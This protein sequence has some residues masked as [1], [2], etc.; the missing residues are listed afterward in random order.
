MNWIAQNSDVVVSVAGAI[1][2]SAAY[3]IGYLI[4]KE[5][6]MDKGFMAGKDLTTRQFT[7]TKE[8]NAI[9]RELNAVTRDIDAI[10]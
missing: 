6:G 8:F 4:G 1:I 9:V 10:R 2:A 5:N 7:R 3:Y